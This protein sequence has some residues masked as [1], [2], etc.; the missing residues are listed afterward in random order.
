MRHNTKDVLQALSGFL[1]EDKV[2]Q[3]G[4]LL[5]LSFIDFS[6]C[7]TVFSPRLSLLPSLHEVR[8]GADVPPHLKSQSIKHSGE[9]PVPKEEFLLALRQLDVLSNLKSLILKDVTLKELEAALSVCGKR[10]SR[11]ELHYMPGVRLGT[12][13]TLA[14]SL[15]HLSISDSVLDL[16][17]GVDQL[18]TYIPNYR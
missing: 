16:V 17:S 10:L 2:R 12:I 4:S 3:D 1:K 18:H 5:S 15:R 8:V 7:F 6:S 9:A 11:L 13:A 14:P